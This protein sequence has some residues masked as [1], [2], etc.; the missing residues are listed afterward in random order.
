M[1]RRKRARSDDRHDRFKKHQGS[2]NEF[3]RKQKVS[4]ATQE[5]YTALAKQFYSEERS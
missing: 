1:I 2:A 5:K 4:P 3:L